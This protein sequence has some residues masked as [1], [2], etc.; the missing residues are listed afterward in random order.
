MEWLDARRDAAYTVEDA[1]DN[2]THDSWKSDLYAFETRLMSNLVHYFIEWPKGSEK[3]RWALQ[4]L[5]RK[6]RCWWPD[7]A[8]WLKD[9]GDTWAAALITAIRNI[10]R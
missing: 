5:V 10:T 9:G 6:P 3:V 8:S 2:E 4:D 7:R 1:P